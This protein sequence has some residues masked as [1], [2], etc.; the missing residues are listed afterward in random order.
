MHPWFPAMSALKNRVF[1]LLKKKAEFKVYKDW[2]EP[3]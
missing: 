2:L 1:A 3:A